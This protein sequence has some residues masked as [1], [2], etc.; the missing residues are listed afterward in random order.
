VRARVRCIVTISP[1]SPRTVNPPKTGL[2]KSLAHS[3]LRLRTRCSCPRAPVTSLCPYSSLCRAVL[4]FRRLCRA[5]QP[6]PLVWRR[7][8][9]CGNVILN[10][11]DGSAL[12]LVLYYISILK[13]VEVHQIRKLYIHTRERCKGALMEI[14]AQHC[15]C[16]SMV[17]YGRAGEAHAVC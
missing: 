15:L 16:E 10:L 7:D 3:K 17:R 8:Q 5:G 2:G 4:C 12:P 1:F 9:P 11:K 14:E 13:L 6:L